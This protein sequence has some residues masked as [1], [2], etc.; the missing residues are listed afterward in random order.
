MLI[1][2]KQQQA[3]QGNRKQQQALSI[4]NE[5]LLCKPLKPLGTVAIA[6]LHLAHLSS[7]VT[8][9]LYIVQYWSL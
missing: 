7:Q 3:T 9:L 1:S 8:L 4:D 5:V 6:S 2:S